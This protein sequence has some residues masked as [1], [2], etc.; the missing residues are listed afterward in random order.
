ME[1]EDT[2]NY[3]IE[4][5][6]IREKE[7]KERINKLENDLQKER[8]IYNISSKNSETIKNMKKEISS[9]ENEIKN[10]MDLNDKQ[11]KQ[12]ELISHEIDLKLKKISND[13]MKMQ[14]LYKILLEI[15][16]K[17]I[18]ALRKFKLYGEELILEKLLIYIMI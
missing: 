18:F 3:N 11:K 17:K 7:L 8:N 9:K 13:K 14:K 2:E 15:V 6:D 4:G 16:L 1:E 12:L 5:K 10:I